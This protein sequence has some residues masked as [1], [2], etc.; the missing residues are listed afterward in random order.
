MEIAKIELSLPTRGEFS[1]NYPSKFPDIA[2]FMIIKKKKF[3]VLEVPII[4]YERMVGKSSITIL[5]RL[6]YVINVSCYL[7]INYLKSKE[8]RL[9]EGKIEGREGRPD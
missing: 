8:L 9:T 3:K 1:R 5:K 4:M 2:V 7:L 6:Y